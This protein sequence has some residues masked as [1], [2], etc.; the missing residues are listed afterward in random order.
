MDYDKDSV[1]D[2]ILGDDDSDVDDENNQLPYAKDSFE[3]PS[4]EA[5]CYSMSSSPSDVSAAGEC[6]ISVSCSPRN[7]SAIVPPF[8]MT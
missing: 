3:S 7:S 4:S 8:V 1:D 5:S 6:L 2:C